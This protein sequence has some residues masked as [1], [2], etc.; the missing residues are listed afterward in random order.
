MIVFRKA[1]LLTTSDLIYIQPGG[2]PRRP[3]EVLPIILVEPPE[4]HIRLR[5][6]WIDT[7]GPTAYRNDKTIYVKP[8]DLIPI[9]IYV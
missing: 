1:D 3:V 2:Q 8:T 6:E 4:L 9:Q 5:F 7:T